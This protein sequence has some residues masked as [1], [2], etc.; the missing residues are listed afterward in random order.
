VVKIPVIDSSE[1]KTLTESYVRRIINLKYLLH[2]P[3]EMILNKKT[4]KRLGLLHLMGLWRG[5]FSENK[6]HNVLIILRILK[7]SIIIFGAVDVYSN[8]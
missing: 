2:K 1:K 7:F 3:K 8:K 6:Q 4:P 5:E